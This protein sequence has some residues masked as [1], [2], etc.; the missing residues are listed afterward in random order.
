MGNF[1]NECPSALPVCQS[2]LVCSKA[3]TKTQ[4]LSQHQQRNSHPVWLLCQIVS[5]GFGVF[6][7]LGEPCH[8]VFKCSFS[9]LALHPSVS[10]LLSLWSSSVSYPETRSPHVWFGGGEWSSSGMSICRTAWEKA[11]SRLTHGL[12]KA[13]STGLKAK[14]HSRDRRGISGE[15]HVRSEMIS[16][17]LG[18]RT[19]QWLCLCADGRRL[20]ACGA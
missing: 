20:Q 13:G 2:W 16:Y 3:D 7:L 18:R 9:A 10:D 14:L 19:V 5:K 12:W 8:L 11:L 1:I 17:G 15:F 4:L 6:C